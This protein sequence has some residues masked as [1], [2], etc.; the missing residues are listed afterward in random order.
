MAAAALAR[1]HQRHARVHRCPGCRQGAR[2]RP[3]RRG[4]GVVLWGRRLG[5]AGQ[6]QERYRL[7][8]GCPRGCGWRPALCVDQRWRT[9]RVSL[10]Y[11]R[12]DERGRAGW[13]HSWRAKGRQG[14]SRVGS[15][16]SLKCTPPAHPPTLQL[17]ADGQ[18]RAV[19]LGPRHRG[20]SWATARTPHSLALT[21]PTTSR[22]RCE[23]W[24]APLHPSAAASSTPAR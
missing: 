4:R 11:M 10:V 16:S 9:P 5:P 14:E 7:C 13:I 15:M 1:P 8:G 20:G 23:W 3:G 18:R 19:V 12:V 6:R 24:V 2:L 21:R 17:C 22:C